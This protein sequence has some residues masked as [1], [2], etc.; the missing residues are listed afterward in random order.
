MTEQWR[1]VTRLERADF[2]SE[3]L[4]HS[5]EN[6]QIVHRDPVVAR[7]KDVLYIETPHD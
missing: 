2:Y 4:R 3:W 6:E 5:Q 7:G 1:A